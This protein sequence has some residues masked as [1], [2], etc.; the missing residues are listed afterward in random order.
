M[1]PPRTPGSDVTPTP[2]SDVSRTPDSDVTPPRTPG[3]D[4]TPTPDS[5]VSRTPDSDVASSRTLDADGRPTR[6]VDSDGVPSHSD[7]GDAQARRPHSDESPRTADADSGPTRTPDVPSRAADPDSTQQRRPDADGARPRTPDADSSTP[8]RPDADSTQQRRPDAVRQPAGDAT[9]PRRNDPDSAAPRRPDVDSTR[10]RTSEADSLRTPDSTG[11]QRTPDGAQRNP[12][13]NGSEAPARGSDGA[14]RNREVDGSVRPED[15]R[16]LTR[17]PPLDETPD[18]LAES[19]DIE[20][21]LE[22]DVYQSADGKWH[23]VLDPAGTFRDVN[24]RLH[25]ANGFCRDP[26]TSSEFRYLAQEGPKRTYKVADPEI[27]RQ[28][29]DIVADRTVVQKRSD[30]ALK[31]VNRLMGEFGVAKLG[32][33]ASSQKLDKVVAEQRRKLEDAYDDLQRDL[34]DRPD[35]PQLQRRETEIIDKLERLDEFERAAAC[36]NR[37][38]PQLVAHSKALGE[39]AARAFGLDPAEFP[40]AVLLSPFDGDIDGRPVIDGANVLDV[41]VYVP[42]TD[43][44]PPAL[45]SHEAKGV[46]S[47]LGGSKVASAEQGSPEYYRRTLRIDNNLHRILAETPEQMRQR[48][49]DPESPE[50]QAL[51]R[52]RNDLL[53]AHRAGTLRFEYHHVHADRNGNVTVSEFDLVR[54]G[55][56]VRMDN[57]GGYDSPTLQ[58]DAVPRTDDDTPVRPEDPDEAARFDADQL[59]APDS[60]EWSNRSPEEVA[61]RLQDHLRQVTGNPEFEV[62]GFDS[63]SVNPEVA[64]EYA[65]A[66]VDLFDRNPTVDLRRV[67]IGELPTGVIGMS[68]PRIDPATGRLYTESIVLSRDHAQSAEYFRQRMQL[69]VDNNRFAPEVLR[70]PVYAVLAHEYGHALDYAGQQSARHQAEDLLIQRYADDTTRDPAQSYDDWLRQLSGYSFDGNGRLRPGEAVPEAFAAQMLRTLGG[71][72]TSPEPVRALHDLV[73]DIAAR[74]PESVTW[75]L[76][77][78]AERAAEPDDVPDRADRDLLADPV[79]DEW[80]DLPPAEVGRHLAERMRDI[81]GHDVET[82]GFDQP[83]VHPAMARELA[84]GIVDMQTRYPSVEV[85]SVGIGETGPGRVAET[86]PERDPNGGYRAKSITFNQQYFAGNGSLF[87]NLMR[88]S[89]PGFYT[90]SLWDRPVYGF[91]VHEF[92]HALDYAGEPRTRKRV[93]LRLHDHYHR[94]RLGDRDGFN[95]WLAGELSGYSMNSR[96]GELNP[97]EALA[98]AFREM[99]ATR[100][101]DGALHPERVSPAVRI[102]YDLLTDAAQVPRSDAMTVDRAAD[103]MQLRPPWE[104][105]IPDLGDLGAPRDDEWS[106]LSPS[107]VGDHLRDVLREAMNNPD[108]DVYGFDLPGLDAEV[109]RDYA[110][111]MV[112]L[113]NAF[114]QTDLRRVGIGDLDYGVLGQTTRTPDRTTGLPYTDITLGYDY[115]ISA[116]HLRSSMQQ[117]VD[118]GHFHPGVL[119]RPVYAI[120]AHEY[121]HAL[122]AAGRLA[123]RADADGTLDEAFHDN[124]DGY[125]DPDSWRRQLSGYSRSGPDGRLNPAEALAEAFTEVLMVGHDRASWPARTLYDLLMREAQNPTRD[126]VH[127]LPEQGADHMELP[128]GGNPDRPE[129]DG[130]DPD[131]SQRERSEPEAGDPDR[132][133]PDRSQPDRSRSD[134]ELT[135]DGAHTDPPRTAQPQPEAPRQNN[136]PEETPRRRRWWRSEQPAIPAEPERRV[137]F[138]IDGEQVVVPLYRDADGEWQ[139]APQDTTMRQAEPRSFLKRALAQLNNHFPILKQP[140]GAPNIGDSAGQAAIRDGVLGIGDMIAN[141]GPAQ[142]PPPSPTPPGVPTVGP[143]PEASAPDPTFLRIAQ[144]TPV[145]IQNREYLPLFGKLSGRVRRSGGEYP[146]MRNEDG[147]EYRP[148]LSDA[149]ADLVRRQ[150]ISDLRV[151]RVTPE[152]AR[153]DLLEAFEHA[154]R[155]QRERILRDMLAND[156]ITQDEADELHNKPQPDPLPPLPPPVDPP[157]P[158]GETLREMFDRLLGVEVADEPDALRRE[159]DRQQYMVMRQT[160]AIIGLGDAFIRAHIEQNAPYTSADGESQAP[161]RFGGRVSMID[162]NPMGRFLTEF[163]AAFGRDPGVLATTP[164]DNGAEPLPMFGDPDAL[165]RDQGLRDFFV[166]ALRR[167]QLAHELDTWAGTFGLG[168]HQLTPDTVDAFVQRLFEI[169]RIRAERLAELIAAV[170]DRLPPRDTDGPTLGEPIRDQVARLPGGDGAPDRLVVTDGARERDQVLADVLASRPDLAAQIRDGDLLVDYR[171]VLTDFRGQTHLEPVDTPQ[172]RDHTENVDGRDVRI[173]LL[174]D[175]DGAW[176]PIIGSD[177]VP[178]D[179]V[180]VQRTREQILA[181]LVDLIFALELTPADVLPGDIDERIAEL[182]LDNA[183]R[184]A[185]VEGLAD[186]LRTGNLVEDFHTVSNARGRLASALGLTQEQMTAGKLGDLLADASRRK[187]LRAQNFDDLELYF[188]TLRDLDSKALDAARQRLADRLVPDSHIHPAHRHDSL[189]A[190][191]RPTTTERPTRK[192]K[193]LARYADLAGVDHRVAALLPPG[194][195]ER[196]GG[197]RDDDKVFAVDP[198]GLSGKKLHQLVRMHEQQGNGELVREAL[199]EFAKALRDIDRYALAP[200]DSKDVVRSENQSDPR[201]DGKEIADPRLV[202]ESMPLQGPDSINAMR[203]V[204]ADALGSVDV[205]DFARAVAEGAGNLDLTVPGN[206]GNTNRPS[207]GRDWARLVGVDLAGADGVTYAKIYEAFRDGKIEKHEGLKPEQMAAVIRELRIEIADRAAKLT[208]LRQ[209]VHDYFGT[210]DNHLGTEPGENTPPRRPQQPGSGLPGEGAPGR[211][212]SAEQQGESGPARTVNGG[213]G[214]PPVQPPRSSSSDEPEDGGHDRDSD[215]DPFDDAAR[216][217]SA[218]TDEVFDRHDEAADARL[219]E[220]LERLTEVQQELEQ[221]LNESPAPQPDESVPARDPQP[222][223]SPDSRIRDILDE[224]TQLRGELDDR[225]V[226]TELDRE[227][228]AADLLAKARTLRLEQLLDQTRREIAAEF[229]ELDRRDDEGPDDDGLPATPD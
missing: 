74:P 83:N 117:S 229:D 11:P 183:V 199:T 64:R 62:F 70:R 145:L 190:D 34:A 81:T 181:D 119:D 99:E 143:G 102:M 19:D 226:D 130:S 142:L 97:G 153:N 215:G 32:D 123:A 227:Q 175:G 84:R 86:A 201:S 65:R 5:D 3:S 211:P 92:G 225:S 4:V 55:N 159:I 125:D 36:F 57:V 116:I 25:D 47:K 46:G 6:T 140:S 146:A 79:N 213:G 195:V 182:K 154:G 75:P 221:G 77:E 42:G 53:D 94:N 2:D 35:D 220:T 20:E 207:A 192:Q 45:I 194:R 61:E 174:R 56:L 107:E 219:A 217:K 209:L 178:G 189:P 80:S 187:A 18:F 43:G 203:R 171:K 87:Q 138:D 169:N 188:G 82:F 208:A 111:S 216:R 179:G 1:T 124:P 144:Q 39:L 196:P 12:E 9:A 44:A 33:I 112:E 135:R 218:A 155:G 24:F 63:D 54:D 158:G 151:E 85:R 177:A 69:G 93:G 100:D 152:D 224:I 186:F 156:L 161:V 22:N 204:I 127:N 95:P 162:Q 48:G 132:S 164:L 104:D 206:V 59:G 68:Q 163:I 223:P 8:R 28:M 66:M 148:E 38:R 13:G 139:V 210:N 15:V 184:A 205:A 73:T 91:A 160:A 78:D 168:P 21:G 170:E 7:A 126:Y 16:D 134:G 172:V 90:R 113:Y 109:V 166:H 165:G 41:V 129:P 176:R 67:G 185:Q 60:D 40:G 118:S 23:H 108:F 173:T 31:I 49:I 193:R 121:G 128:D 149:D 191:E 50:G 133:Q 51:I 37:L 89:K 88:A 106:D 120:A 30:D 98:E 72:D 71:D 96:T 180:T 110:R 27:A 131:R 147:S 101:A 157:P 141:P 76:S 214:K 29:A 115:A 58:S 26:L 200:T 14:D 212:N 202:R 137:F 222:Q 10:Q 17:R 197:H 52:A 122:D 198:K 114:P 136:S 167:D 150:I 103:E 228:L 105:D